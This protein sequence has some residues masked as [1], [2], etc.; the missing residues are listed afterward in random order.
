M[1]IELIDKVFSIKEPVLEGI[2]IF[3]VKAYLKPVLGSF[4]DRL[5]QN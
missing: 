2:L 1:P 3:L 4:K 5:L